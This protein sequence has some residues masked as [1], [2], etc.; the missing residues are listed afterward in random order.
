MRAGRKRRNTNSHFYPLR[1]GSPEF[2]VLSWRPGMICS[3]ILK[4]I[5]HYDD[6]SSNLFD[7]LSFTIKIFWFPLKLDDSGWLGREPN[8]TIQFWFFFTA[9]IKS[10]LYFYVFKYGTLTF[11]TVLWIKRSF[12]MT[13]CIY[14]KTKG[15]T[16]KNCSLSI[17]WMLQ[18]FR[19]K[20]SLLWLLILNCR[21][22][23]QNNAWTL[24]HK[25]LFLQ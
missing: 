19:K 24:P 16:F 14:L 2:A 9:A 8:W 25:Y 18:L 11:H 22:A 23:Q 13:M 20:A 6:V 12:T 7:F 21:K 4:G 1:E 5:V 17:M 15:R 10:H 3:L